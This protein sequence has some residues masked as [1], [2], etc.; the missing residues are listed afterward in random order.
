MEGSESNRQIL[1]ETLNF[2]GKLCSEDSIVFIQDLLGYPMRRITAVF[3]IFVN[4]PGMN[5]SGKMW[6]HWDATKR[7]FI[8]IRSL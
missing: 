4:D 5:S 3:W 7:V 8:F 1:N 2:M 6:P